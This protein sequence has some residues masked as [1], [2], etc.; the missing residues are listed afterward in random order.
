MSGP[1]PTLRR[2]MSSGRMIGSLGASLDEH[3]T[4]RDSWRESRGRKMSAV[5]EERRSA[6]EMDEADDAAAAAAGR[7]SWPPRPSL[8]P[9]GGGERGGQVEEVSVVGKADAAGLGL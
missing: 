8:G 3:D 4:S 2:G 5:G 1:S 6:L 9:R 7:P